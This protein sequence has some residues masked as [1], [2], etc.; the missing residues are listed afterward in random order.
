[1]S[2]NNLGFVEADST[3]CLIESSK[4]VKWE[5]VALFVAFLN[6]TKEEIDLGQTSYRLQLNRVGDS[7]M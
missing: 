4:F 2:A 6:E 5:D 3:Q 1:M 7:M